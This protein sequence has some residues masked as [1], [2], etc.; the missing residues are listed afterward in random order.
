MVLMLRKAASRAP[1]VI[2]VKDLFTRRRG[3][4]STAYEKKGVR[5]KGD[6]R[7]GGWKLVQCL[8]VNYDIT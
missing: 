6:E 4:T 8:L 2:K 3:E 7:G 5:Q 1:T